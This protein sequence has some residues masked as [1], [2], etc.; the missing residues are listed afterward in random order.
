MVNKALL[1][2]A[3]IYANKNQKPIDGATRFQKL[4][5]LAQEEFDVQSI[6]GDEYEYQAD[7]YG[8]F[9]P[10]F[11]TALDQLQNKGFLEKEEETTRAGNEK[12]TFKLTGKGRQAVRKLQAEEE[13]QIRE[14]LDKSSLLM[15]NYGSQPLERLLR[16]VYNKYPDYTSES[17]L[18]L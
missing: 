5:F 14:L 9:S 4:V 6:L 8:P 7:K 12:H 15:E 1:P 2:L 18:E 3:L 13:D 16:Y 10:E 11:A 17:E